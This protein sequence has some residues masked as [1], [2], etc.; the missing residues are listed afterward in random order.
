MTV[1]IGSVI[2]NDTPY[3]VFS[4]PIRGQLEELEGH[5]C[6][7]MGPESVSHIKAYISTVRETH[8]KGVNKIH[9]SNILVVSEELVSKAIYKSTQMC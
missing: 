8:G 6:D 4:D 1:S 9:L 5:I 2:K 7:I 3:E